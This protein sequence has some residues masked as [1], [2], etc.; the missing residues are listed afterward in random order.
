MLLGLI[1]A[2]YGGYIAYLSGFAL[3]PALGLAG[4]G[5]AVFLAG[6]FGYIAGRLVRPSL[7]APSP[8]TTPTTNAGP[9]SSGGRHEVNWMLL[10]VRPPPRAPSASVLLRACLPARIVSPL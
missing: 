1:V 3:L 10:V 8:P 4:L 6:L 2:A 5:T 7:K 9:L